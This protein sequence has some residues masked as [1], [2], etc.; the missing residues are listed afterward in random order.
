MTQWETRHDGQ[1]PGQKQP[2]I[3]IIDESGDVVIRFLRSENAG[4]APVCDY[5]VSS[6]KLQKASRYY[7]AMIA[8]G[9]FSEG[10]KFHST[11][12]SLK[13]RYQG[14]VHKIPAAELP[15]L[16]FPKIEQLTVTNMTIRAVKVFMLLAHGMQD[17][18]EKQS[19]CL[20]AHLTVVAEQI[21]GVHTTTEYAN[22]CLNKVK[23]STFD[24][25]KDLTRWR[26]LVYLAY[27]YNR[28]KMFAH[29]TAALV[30]FGSDAEVSTEATTHDTSEDS[31]TQEA[32]Q[33]EQRMP[34]PW[35]LDD[36]EGMEI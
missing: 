5:R 14:K 12:D 35:M 6:E 24:A 17:P 2:K 10:A 23:L 3:M 25:P 26:Q 8:P 13:T 16:L 21:L 20:L 29:F 30:D 1:D 4:E 7:E 22:Q 32:P 28:P 19:V 27:N 9:R 33:S 36:I 31:G 11:I 18:S 34:S 15:V